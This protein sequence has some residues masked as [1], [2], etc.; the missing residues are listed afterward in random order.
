MCNTGHAVNSLNDCAVCSGPTASIYR[1][2]LGTS[3]SFAK[4]HVKKTHVSRKAAGKAIFYTII[5]H[6][7]LTDKEAKENKHLSLICFN[8]SGRFSS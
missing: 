8:K 7:L 2:K 1:E 3:H 4:I 5:L 6:D